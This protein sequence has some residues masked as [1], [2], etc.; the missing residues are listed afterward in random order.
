[1][2]RIR[3]GWLWA[4]AALVLIAL[5]VRSDKPRTSAPAA[6]GHL[7]WGLYQILWSRSY[8]EELRREVARFASRPNYVMFY[9]DLGRPFPRRAV[10]A[11]HEIG[12]TPMVSLE[13]WRWHGGNK[14]S[15]LPAIVRGDYDAFLRDWACAARTDGRRVLLRFGFEFNG[16]WFTWSLDPRGFV[17]AWRHAR[18]IFRRE[19]ADNVEWV[20]SPNAANCP[21][22][23]DNDMHRYYPGDTHV[24]WLSLDG[25]NFGEHHDQWHHWQSFDEVFGKP[26]REFEKRHPSKPVILSEFGCA[27][28]KSRRRPQWIRDAHAALARYPQVRA[29]IWFNLD[30]RREGEPNWRLNV[31]AESLRAFNETFARPTPP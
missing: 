1:M 27:S 7:E 23:P 13:L 14:D 19:K 31:T 9:R 22:T 30:K 25:Y 15:Y 21:D 20:W 4:G 29:A 3:P 17:A 11:I 12:A 6:S 16:N 18:E 2:R 26:L 8:A 24:D 10:D 5:G 28:G